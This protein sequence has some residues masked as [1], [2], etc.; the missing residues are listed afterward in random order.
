MMKRKRALCLVLTTALTVSSLVGLTG[1]QKKGEK[2]SSSNDKE[3]VEYLKTAEYPIK[4]DKT[5]TAWSYRGGTTYGTYK[6]DELPCLKNLEEKTGIKIEWTFANADEK[7]QFNLLVASGDLP[8]MISYMWGVN[9]DFPG[10]PERAI[11]DGYIT[12][13]D[14]LMNDYAPNFMEYLSDNKLAQREL[15]TDSG[16]YY[17]VP[18]YVTT[19][20][21]NGGTSNGY[22]FRKDWLDELGLEVPET[23]DE[24]YTVL[25]AFKEKKGASAPFSLAYSNLSRGMTNPF[26]IALGLYN[27]NGTAKYG[28]A[29]EGYRQFL[30]EM[31]KWYKEGLIDRNI[32]TI[33]GKGIDAN[34]LNNKTGAAHYWWSSLRNVNIAGKEKD[35]DFSLVGVKTPVKNKGDVPKFVPRDSMVY[36]AGFAISKDSNNKELAMKFLDY[37][38]SPEGRELMQF[39][40]EGETF[41]IEDGQYKFTDLITNNPEGYSVSEA[42]AIYIRNT[43]NI[44]MIQGGFEDLRANYVE[45]DSVDEVNESMEKWSIQDGSSH[46]MSHSVAPGVELASE[47]A[48]LQ[49]EIGTYASE[50][51]LKF[52]LGEEP[53]KNF[54]AYLA[55]LNKRGLKRYLEITQDCLDRYQNR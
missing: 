28:Y 29:E 47:Y 35:P 9:A 34:I 19:K 32:A 25:K 39:G 7:Q 15:K 50:M 41:V 54:D 8:D 23:I 31:N 10:G 55:E 38:F 17:Y 3:F 53:L 13:L 46:K 36:Y 43:E 16:N 48:K 26:G 42:T 22:A 49:T 11:A 6:A 27:D 24:W 18:N 12:P 52:I 45:H 1:C 37:G 44:P 20:E 51:F 4:T 30:T 14:D 5:L 40:I 33:D 21:L 2:T